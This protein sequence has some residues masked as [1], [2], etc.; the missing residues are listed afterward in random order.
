M[1]FVEV[2]ESEFCCPC[3]ST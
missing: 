3:K 2:R 1:R